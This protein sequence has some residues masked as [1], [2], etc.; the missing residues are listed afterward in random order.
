M[1]DAPNIDTDA[2]VKALLSMGPE[3]A[4]RALLRAK[5][6]R[7]QSRRSAQKPIRQVACERTRL[8]IKDQLRMLLFGA[9]PHFAHLAGAEMLERDWLTWS[10]EGWAPGGWVSTGHH[11]QA[12]VRRD[13]HGNVSVKVIPPDA[14]PFPFWTPVIGNA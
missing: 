11:H 5:G 10:P 14:A 8:L 13:D 4:K 7:T 3:A 6:Y 9:D 12:E 2:L 1:T